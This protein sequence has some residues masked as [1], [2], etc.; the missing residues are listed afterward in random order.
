M[1]LVGTPTRRDSAD[2]DGPLHAHG[3]RRR[4]EEDASPLNRPAVEASGDVDDDDER[5]DRAARAR[6]GPVAP[7]PARPLPCSWCGATSLV[8]GRRAGHR[9]CACAAHRAALIGWLEGRTT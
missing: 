1:A 6:T 2:G 3:S 4:E 9:R 7:S 8:Y 5:L